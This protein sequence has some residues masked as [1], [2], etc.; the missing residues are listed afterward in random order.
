MRQ[1]RFWTNLASLRDLDR[2]PP[3]LCAVVA[4]DG[5]QQLTYAQIGARAGISRIGVMRIAKRTSWAK[6]SL[7]T[8]TR[9][10]EA[11]GVNLLHPGQQISYLKRIKRLTPRQVK[12]LSKLR[13]A[14]RLAR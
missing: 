2:F 10:S 13:A 6:L 1:H 5:R 12:L 3:C 8:I 11:C 14:P 7:D 9:Y 4:R